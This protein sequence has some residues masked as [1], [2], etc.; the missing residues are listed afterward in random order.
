[1][2]AGAEEKFMYLNNRAEEVKQE[3]HNSL[4]DD[5]RVPSSAQATPPKSSAVAEDPLQD[6]AAIDTTGWRP[7]NHHMRL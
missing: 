6:A 7:R 5:V 2:R 4:I 1:M 3:I